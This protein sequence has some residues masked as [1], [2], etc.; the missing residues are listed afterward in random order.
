MTRTRL[1]ATVAAG[2]VAAAVGVTQLSPDPRTLPR[3]DG[4][5]LVEVGEITYD[6]PDGA[7]GDLSYGSGG[8][9][10]SE[11]GKYLYVPCN[12]TAARAGVAKL[13]IP[14]GENG[15]ARVVAPCSGPTQADIKKVVPGW[16][17]GA[18]MIGGTVE[19]GGRV[20]VSAY[21]SYDANG[22]A[23]ASHFCG[24]SL[25][26]LAGPFRATVTPGL[27][28][29]AMGIVPAEWRGL[30]GG[31]AFATSGYTSIIS[32]QSTGAVL[33]TFDPATATADGFQA[34]LLL[35]CPYW[36]SAKCA[37][38]WSAW[39]PS[40]DFFGG[41]EQAGPTFF[42]PGTRTLAVI[43]RE[44]TGG[45]CYGYATTDPALHG[46]PYP[47]PEGVRWCYS[48]SD[49]AGQKGNK[50]Y[51]YKRVVKLYDL[52][53]L[54]DVKAGLKKPEDV[55]Q[56]AT[57]TLPGSKP[58]EFITGGTFNH[59]TNKV[60]LAEFLGGGVNRVKVL[61]GAAAPP[62][63]PPPPPVPTVS[64]TSSAASVPAG[65]CVTLTYT[66]SSSAVTAAILPDVG[67]VTGTNG[68]VQACPVQSTDYVLTAGN[69]S[70]AA[71]ATASVV[72]TTPPPPPPPPNP[73]VTA[74][75]GLT[76]Q[77][78]PRTGPAATA[79]RWTVTGPVG[80]TVG[81]EWFASPQ[82]AQATDSRGCTSPRVVR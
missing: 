35:A 17:A 39:G 10:V 68:A 40:D 75:L 3:W 62:P 59:V 4:S 1:A 72:V 63:P 58:N 15:P 73:C 30:L 7:G 22:A 79:A 69:A 81:V 29:G 61:A 67:T 27:V 53:D 66:V 26:Q 65:Q 64:L 78:W 41:A 8:M 12:V 55:D 47:S 76:V 77:A 46:K 54:A 24:P 36:A 82:A 5:G 33:V 49:P 45:E 70:G 31:S 6:W 52:A 57:V 43:E 21:G 56:Y 38:R 18:P 13:E 14:V 44:G 20:C 11:D 80:I 60:Y 74:P 42:V 51:P 2:A 37:S 50:A 48:L 23:I 9:S 71:S 28:K 32:R 34:N 19:Q 16:G 25:T